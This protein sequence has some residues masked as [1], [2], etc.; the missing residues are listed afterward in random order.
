[1]R[2]PTQKQKVLQILVRDGSWIPTFEFQNRCGIFVG[3]RGPAR[4][5]ELSI[6]Y[7]EMVETDKTGKVYKYRFRFDNVHMALEAYPTWR[8]LL[9]EELTNAGRSF[10]QYKTIYE[11]VPG[12]NSVRPVRV[13]A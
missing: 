3:H 10:K 6:E 7:P 9:R 12:T 5:S 1:M 13:L 4:I 8:K 11:P 2:G